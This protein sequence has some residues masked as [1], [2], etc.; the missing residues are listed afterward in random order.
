VL[1]ALGDEPGALF[2]ARPLERMLDRH[3]VSMS[4]DVATAMSSIEAAVSGTL[5]RM[6]MMAV[7]LAG[8]SRPNGGITVGSGGAGVA[9]TPRSMGH[10]HRY[11]RDNEY[12]HYP[13]YHHGTTCGIIHSV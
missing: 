13:S 11:K 1:V 5:V 2:L 4:A 3:S 8:P 12:D 10:D 6:V 9:F 7:S